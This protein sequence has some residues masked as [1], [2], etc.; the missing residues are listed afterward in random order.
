MMPPPG[1]AA[2][3]AFAPPMPMQ[4]QQQQPLMQAPGLLPPVGQD[5]QRLSEAA[6]RVAADAGRAIAQL[7][8]CQGNGEI[9]LNAHVQD[10]FRAFRALLSDMKMAVD[11]QET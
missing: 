4:Q 1:P 2:P 3:G 5:E 8:G 6:G 10:I 9:E 7:A 11:E